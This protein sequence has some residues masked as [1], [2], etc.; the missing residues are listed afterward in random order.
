MTAEKIRFSNTVM[1]LAVVSLLGAGWRVAKAYEAMEV[2]DGGAIVGTVKFVGV[3]P[4]PEPLEVTR[5]RIECGVGSHL[6][7]SLITSEESGIQNVVVS[8]KDIGKGKAHPRR[9]ENIALVQE[10]CRFKPHVLLVPADSTVDL[11]NNDDITHHIHTVSTLNP[12]VDLVQPGFKKRLRIKL[13]DPEIIQVNCEI[14]PWMT[15]WFVV[16]GHPYYVITDSNGAFALTDIPPGIYTLHVW[17][18]TLGT[19]SQAVVVMAD[20]ETQVIIEMKLKAPF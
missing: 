15:A 10:K 16:T 9:D 6:S 12:A 11:R 7:E 3:P 18:E 8:L 17:H 2:K 14:H 1:L 19:H 4:V 20:K 5:D 13:R